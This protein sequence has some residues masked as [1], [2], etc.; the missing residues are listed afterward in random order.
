VRQANK[1]I[2]YAQTTKLQD[3]LANLKANLDT[4][5]TI[6]LQR[7]NSHTRKD[8]VSAFV[9][10]LYYINLVE[11]EERKKNNRDWSKA[12]FSFLN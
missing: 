1:L 2:P 8:L 4:N 6:V 5:S 7:I 12:Q 3:Q 9:Y 11:E 10:G